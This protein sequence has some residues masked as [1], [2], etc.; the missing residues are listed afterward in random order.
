MDT[1]IFLNEFN[2]KKSVSNT[3]GLNV[4]LDGRRKL[5]QSTDT[6]HV[7]SAYE[8][9]EKERKA[10]NI[11]RLTCQVNPVCSN[12][13]FNRVT[14]VVKDEGSSG[15]TMLNYGFSGASYNVFDGVKY[16]E[17][18]MKFW[19]GNTA[20][21]QSVDSMASSLSHRTTITQ[22]VRASSNNYDNGQ[23]FDNNGKPVPED[24]YKKACGCRID[25]G[26]YYGPNN[27]E[28]TEEEYTRVCNPKCYCDSNGQCYDDNGNPVTEEE[29]NKDCNPKCYCDSNGQCY[30]GKG[31]PVTPEQ[32]QK[33]CGCRKENGKF[34][35]DKGNEVDEKTWNAKCVPGTGS[36]APYISILTL[37]LASYGI[38]NIIKYYKNNKKIYKV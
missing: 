24:E 19:S 34:Y 10:C 25:N 14:E 21:Y 4:A 2:S 32:Y 33:A 23:C 37:L 7:I 12:V 31:K 1:Q 22:A 5:I 11:V 17:Q 18:S 28:I 16:K 35:D 38:I 6:S 26:K 36:F 20:F 30:D 9:Y 8:Q 15:L 13:L 3:S 27:E 29:Y